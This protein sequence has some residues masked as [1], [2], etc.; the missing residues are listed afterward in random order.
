MHKLGS[1]M[2]KN[3]SVDKILENKDTINKV[4]DLDSG[5]KM[6]IHPDKTSHFL[7]FNLIDIQEKLFSIEHNYDLDTTLN[8][9]LNGNINFGK[10]DLKPELIKFFRPLNIPT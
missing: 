1:H 2:L 6:Y 10:R 7:I 3:T 5:F 4:I 8:N 9:F